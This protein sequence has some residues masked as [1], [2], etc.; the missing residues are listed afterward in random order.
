M[1]A[2]VLLADLK[3]E[4]TVPQSAKFS[5][6]ACFFR[7]MAQRASVWKV[8]RAKPM[9]MHRPAHLLLSGR[10]GLVML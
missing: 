9:D 4:V 8:K 7:L 10:D 2:S 3:A 5:G 1:S 6:F